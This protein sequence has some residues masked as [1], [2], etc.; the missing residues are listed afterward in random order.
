[1]HRVAQGANASGPP[2]G[3]DDTSNGRGSRTFA[4]AAADNQA[5]SSLGD[6]NRMVLE[7]GDVEVLTPGQEER[8]QGRIYA[9][10]DLERDGDAVG[11]GCWRS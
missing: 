3:F 8:V 10:V 4:H 5:N 9:L 6:P 2:G 11:V 1:M 7:C